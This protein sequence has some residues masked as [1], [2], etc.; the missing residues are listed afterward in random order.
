MT[1]TTP[2]TDTLTQHEGVT[3]R[4]PLARPLILGALLGI[5]MCLPI[6]TVG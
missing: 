2:S 3:R 5:V 1:A 6:F 4:A